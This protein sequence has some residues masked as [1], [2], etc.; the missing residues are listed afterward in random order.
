MNVFL[1]SHGYG[2]EGFTDPEFWDTR[3]TQNGEKQAKKINDN[4][5]NLVGSLKM[6]FPPL[7][8]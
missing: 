4:I 6:H 5:Q 3:L 7:S 1:M 8:S 2:S